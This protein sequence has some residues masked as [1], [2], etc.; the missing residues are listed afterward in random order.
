V[1]GWLIALQQHCG[2][3]VEE[4]ARFPHWIPTPQIESS[5]LNFLHRLRQFSSQLSLHP[6]LLYVK[7]FVGRAFRGL[8]CLDILRPTR[9]FLR[10]NLATC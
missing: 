3:A 5:H 9:Y 8:L 2:S 10:Y 4:G 7:D 6:Q 1:T